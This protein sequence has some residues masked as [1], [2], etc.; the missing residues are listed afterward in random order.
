MQ[1]TVKPGLS[2]QWRLF[3][4]LVAMCLLLVVC[5]VGFQYLREKQYKADVLNAELQI[6]NT[7]V[8][9]RLEEGHHLEEWLDSIDIPLKDLRVTVF[10]PE[11][12][13]IFDNTLENFPAGSHLHKREIQRALADGRAY[14]LRTNTD[15]SKPSFFYSVLYDRD[16]IIRSGAPYYSASVGEVLDAD[17]TF[18]WFMLGVTILVGIIG[19]YASR[20]IGQTISRLSSFATAAEKGEMITRRT[21]FPRDE[22][23]EI[24]SNIV[25]LYQQLYATA[26]E[27]DR[28]QLML[29][30]E[31]EEKQ[32]LKRELTQNIN[33][34]LKTPVASVLGC[35]ETLQAHPDLPEK[36]RN[37]FI[38]R[39]VTNSQRLASLLRDISTINRLD[40]AR[41]I[42]EKDLI[43]LHKLVSEVVTDAT[44]RAA[45][46]G[47]ALANELPEDLR[48]RGNNPL[49]DS[50]FRNLVEN[51]I[52]YSGGTKLTI[53]L[54]ER[55]PH[56][57]TISVA[58]NGCGIPEEHFP[59]IF[60]RFY[61][62][63]KG[64][65]RKAGGTGLGLA[66]VENAV[67]FHD[68][69]ITIANLPTGGLEFAIT[70][71]SPQ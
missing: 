57:F 62:I 40:E 10:N 23:G 2:Y 24:A 54:I 8:L 14:T 66:I 60:E 34:E 4:I 26:E 12:R 61:R 59:R 71:P 28:Q 1:P 51:S 22:L 30:K 21:N 25:S 29:M 32:R 55:N 67:L 9:D 18:L 31:E 49:L 37:Q 13:I 65:S 69:S 45:A 39:I 56:Q 20:S 70:F 5:F 17:S 16:Y 52:A 19:F 53:S 7:Q 6:F 38:D 68:G 63:D 46:A 64:R 44:P 35:A 47:M 43:N 11:G 48:L 27:R 41:G 42:M 36:T 50:V 58:D 33:H 3:S 15:P